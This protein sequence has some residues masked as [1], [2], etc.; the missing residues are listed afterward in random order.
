MF[1]LCVDFQNFYGPLALALSQNT[2]FFL[3]RLGWLGGELDLQQRA[4]VP[5]DRGN[6]RKHDL[7][8]WSL[9]GFHARRLRRS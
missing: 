6:A 8:Q 1:G 2:R 5:K 9:W 3:C 7:G 4:L